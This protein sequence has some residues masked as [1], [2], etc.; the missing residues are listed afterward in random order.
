MKLAIVVFFVGSIL[1]VAQVLAAF[2]DSF[3]TVTQM[4]MKGFEKGLPLLYHAGI[5]GDLLITPVLAYIVAAHASEWHRN[6]IVI[7]HVIGVVL[8]V[9]MGLVWVNGAKNGLPEAHTYGGKLT[10]AG[11]IHAV[12][13][14]EAIAGIILFFFFSK[15]SQTEAEL[16]AAFLAIHVVYGTHIFLGLAA[17]EWFPNRPH[18][19]PVTWAVIGVSWTALIW[20]CM[21]I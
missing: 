12:Y 19:D 13:F 17:P 14:I 10:V 5:W 8:I 21:T 3:L 4:R 16:V 1:V 6:D 11:W 20:R 15:I 2:L 7:A 18:K 9:V